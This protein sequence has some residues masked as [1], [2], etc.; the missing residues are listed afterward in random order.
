MDTTWI[1]VANAGRARFFQQDKH[2]RL[3]EVND[4]VNPKGRLRNP[5]HGHIDARSASKSRHGT[6]E[7][8][9]PSDYQPRQLPDEHQTALLARDVA[10]FLLT[11]LQAG[12]YRHL[13]LSASPRFLGMLRQ[14]LDEQVKAT[15]ALEINQDY[16]QLSMQELPGK[17]AAHAARG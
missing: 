10:D 13:M 2:N 1:V 3:V 16:T 8:A 12:Q 7:P 11:A 6:A 17:L 9:Q 5:E 14:V 15:V 4:M